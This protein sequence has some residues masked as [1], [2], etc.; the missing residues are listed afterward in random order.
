MKIV[1][2]LKSDLEFI[3]VIEDIWTIRLR[4]FVVYKNGNLMNPDTENT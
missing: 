3:T 4:F 2:E 1:H